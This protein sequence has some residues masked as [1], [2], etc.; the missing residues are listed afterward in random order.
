MDQDVGVRLVDDL[1]VVDVM[2]RVEESRQNVHVNGVNV[3]AVDDS[4]AIEVSHRTIAEINAFDLESVAEWNR[5]DLLSFEKEIMGFYFSG[6]P[7]DSYRDK[8]RATVDLDLSATENTSPDKVYNLLGLVRSV[9]EIQTRRGSKM[10]FVQLEDYNGSIELVVFSEQWE[11]NRELLVPDN[12]VGVQGKIDATR[13]DP[14]IIVDQMMSPDTMA[15]VSPKEIH[16]RLARL[17]KDEEELYSLRSFLIDRRGGC[18]L[19]LHTQ[20]RAKDKDIVI[21]ASPQLC[22]S[23]QTDVL[24]QIRDLPEV[25]AVWHQ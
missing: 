25:E 17:I 21:K 5:L 9:R 22:I 3:T 18:A 10:A 8:W 12:V 6:H 19:F 14:K 16:I 1:I 7:L 15:D 24:E 2:S 23:N 11:I 20:D 4:V 13:G